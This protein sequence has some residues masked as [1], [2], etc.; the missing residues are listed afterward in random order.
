VTVVAAI[1]LVG[2]IL[3]IA[4]LTLPAAIA[5][6]YTRTLVRM[7]PLAVLLAALFTVVGLA[8]AFPPD[9]PVGPTII[10][11]TGTAY[12]ASTLGGRLLGGRI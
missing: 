3:V 9:L 12:L 1:R 8:A 11:I 10:L 6:Q 7:M 4:L 2:L 5:R